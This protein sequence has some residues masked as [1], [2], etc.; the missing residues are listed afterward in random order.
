MKNWEGYKVPLQEVPF[1]FLKKADPSQKVVLFRGASTDDSLDSGTL[2]PKVSALVLSS[3]HTDVQTDVIYRI[4]TI[5]RTAP[6]IIREVERV[7]ERKMSAIFT[8]GFTFAGGVKRGSRNTKLV[9]RTTEKISRKTTGT[10]MP[11]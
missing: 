1:Q 6:E 9:E 11:N 4:A 8:Q 2:E 5:D 3:L 7:L 10:R